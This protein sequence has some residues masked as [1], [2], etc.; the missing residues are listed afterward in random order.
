MAVK[1]RTAY[2]GGSFD[3]PHRGHTELARE[4]LAR[5]LADEVW[6]APA[7]QPPHKARTQAS[8]ADR[9]AMVKLA[10]EGVPGVAACGDEAEFALEPSYTIDVLAKLAEKYPGRDF[11]LLIGGDMLA[12]FH[13]W[14]R[15]RELAENVRILA[16]PRRGSAVELESLGKHWPPA[17]AEKLYGSL[18]TGMPFFDISSTNIRNVLAKSGNAGNIIDAKV[19]NYINAAGLYR[20]EGEKELSENTSTITAAELAKLCCELADERKAEDIV[21][22]EIG[23]ISFIADYFV[24]CSGNSTTQLAAV[25][26]RVERGVREKT[27][28]R[29]LAVEGDSASGWVLIDFGSVVVHIMTTE[30]RER[31][32]IE[33]LWGD[34]PSDEVRQALQNFRPEQEQ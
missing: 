8:F 3:P 31:Y 4:V 29:P 26:S 1:I 30:M 19:M 25:Q 6:L 16:C 5:G 20:R 24:I 34:A 33:K 17:I 22:L 14:H 15:A 7:W 28:R 12:D 9:L 11:S 2:F 18:L 27:E 32:Q 21:A 10:C 23:Q 13:L